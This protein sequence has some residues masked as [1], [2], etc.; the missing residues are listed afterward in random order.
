M[1]KKLKKMSIWFDEV[2]RIIFLRRRK[3]NGARIQNQL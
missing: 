3:L 1:N 2:L